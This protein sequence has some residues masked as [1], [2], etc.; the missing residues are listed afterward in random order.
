MC[1][2]GA[3]MWCAIVLRTFVVSTGLTVVQ[4]TGQ[5]AAGARVC[6]QPMSALTRSLL[7]GERC[8]MPVV[9]LLLESTY[10]LVTIQI[11]N[12]VSRHWQLIAQHGRHFALVTDRSV[13]V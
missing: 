1:P 13:G 12:E 6:N 4:L 7:G 10:G 3:G 11:S 8:V 5:H 9:P 2:C